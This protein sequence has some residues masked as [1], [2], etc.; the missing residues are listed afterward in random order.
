MSAP[1]RP[2]SR[3]SPRRWRSAGSSSSFG[4]GRDED[5]VDH[6]VRVKRDEWFRYHEQLSAW[7]VRE[8]L[9]RF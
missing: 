3:R 7:E 8:Y 1:A 6:H 2:R 4:R 9:A 5:Y